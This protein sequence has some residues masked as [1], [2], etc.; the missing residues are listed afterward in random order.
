MKKLKLLLLSLLCVL[1][2]I[3]SS[4]KI[5]LA[6][7]E[8]PALNSEGVVLMDANSGQVVFSKNPDTKYFPASTTKILTA[9][10]VLEKSK[11]DEKVTIGKNPPFAE[12]TSIGLRE[13]E[14]YTVKELLSGLLLE[15]GNDCAEALAEHVSSSKEE[16]AKLMNSRAKELGCNNSNFKNPSGLP[17][18]EHYTTPR[19]LALIMKACTKSSDFVAISRTVNLD[20]QPSAIDGYVRKTNNHNLILFPSSK[21]YYKY[22]VASKKGYTIAAKFT[23]AI[24]AT[25]NGKTYVAT[26]L[27]GD[28][29]NEVYK[30]VVDIF[31]YGFDNFEDKKIICEGDEVGSFTVSDGIKIPLLASEDVY[32]TVPIGD[33]TNIKSEVKFDTPT[34]FDDID[35]KRGDKITTCS[36]MIKDEMIKSIDLVSGVN[37]ITDNAVD[38]TS[39]SIGDHKYTFG[40][41]A[42][43]IL[44]LIFRIIS[45]KRKRSKKSKKK[46]A[47][48]KDQ[49]YVLKKKSFNT[50][51]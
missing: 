49:K 11:L 8:P 37:K 3:N 23:N 26:F 13:G 33:K 4:S 35:L 17:D 46:S 32:Y 15:S 22:S 31:D 44:L 18:D 40:L 43:I 9:L 41:S 30:D 45:V 7:A 2:F 27:R 24:S 51:K 20:F 1:L 14:I 34:G 50:R 36:V 42:A 29:I 16:F 21:Y 5:T 38:S 6:A 39:N 12:G 25:K 19:D 28:G 48:N 10:I 47:M